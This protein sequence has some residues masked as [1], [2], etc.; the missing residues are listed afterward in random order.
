MPLLQEVEPEMLATITARLPRSTTAANPAIQ[1]SE[2][3]AAGL[4]AA[5]VAATIKALEAAK[6]AGPAS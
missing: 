4:S 5:D 2:R 6:A 1:G 3:F